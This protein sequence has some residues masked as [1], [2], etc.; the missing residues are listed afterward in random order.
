MDIVEREQLNLK[1]VANHWYYESKYQLLKMHLHALPLQMDSFRTVD[2][3]TG[4]G[5]FL[6]KLELDKL[7]SPTRSAGIDPG[8]STAG[9]VFESNI[10]IFPDFPAGV[11]FD[12][13]L[14]MDVLEHVEDDKALLSDVISHMDNRGYM[15]ITVPAL[16]MLWSG[17]DRFLGHFR[18]YTLTSLRNLILSTGEL[19]IISLHYHFASILPVVIP[20]RLL[21]SF[22]N[23]P[24]SSDMRP[25]PTILNSILKKICMLELRCCQKNLVAGLSVVA[26]CKK[27]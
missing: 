6:H 7:A 26:L 27:K 16:P 1:I 15:F 12:L 3:G 4:L 9:N 25:I 2:V 17:H 24:E 5:L 11:K 13:A 14:L 10:P 8:Y 18:R 19:E 22:T 23:N 20:I 21:N